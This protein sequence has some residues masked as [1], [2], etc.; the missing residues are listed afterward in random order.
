MGFQRIS[1]ELL[2]QDHPG[3]DW[4]GA[5][6]WATHAGFDERGWHWFNHR[7]LV[8]S[9]EQF[10]TGVLAGYDRDLRYKKVSNTAPA[11]FEKLQYAVRPGFIEQEFVPMQDKDVVLSGL[12][13]IEAA[14]VHYR[15]GGEK[16]DAFAPDYGICGNIDEMCSRQS[17][18]ATVKDNLICQTPSFSGN[19]SYPVPG[20]HGE[21]PEEAW[22]RNSDKWAGEYGANRLKQLQELIALVETQWDDKYTRRMSPAQRNGFE[23]GQKFVE[24]STGDIWIFTMDDDSANPQFTRERDG[25]KDWRHLHKMQRVTEVAKRSVKAY[26]KEAERILAKQAKLKAKAEALAQELRGLDAKLAAVDA[27]LSLHHR[28]RRV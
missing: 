19:F 21:G 3:L 23:V 1:E 20:V 18:V 6:D 2:I 4:S 25:E 5:P 9:Q 28:V 22:D 24:I 14:A 13:K 27:A 26:I 8:Y 16:V 17:M 12:R 7:P 15:V 11:Q 10:C